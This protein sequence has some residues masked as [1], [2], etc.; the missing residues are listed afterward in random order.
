M[1]WEIHRDFVFISA[2]VGQRM[3]ALNTLEK[4]TPSKIFSINSSL[5][6]PNQKKK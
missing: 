6:V 3:L 2:I 1:G 4:Q 5:H